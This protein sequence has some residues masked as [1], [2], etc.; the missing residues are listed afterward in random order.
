MLE[1]APMVGG[2][3][4]RQDHRDYDAALKKIRETE[5]KPESV[6]TGDIA[7]FCLAGVLAVALYLAP[8]KTPLWVCLGLTCMAALATHPVLN[9]PWIKKT[10]TREQRIGRRALGLCGM[11][12]L[13]GLYGWFVWPK[14][15]Y[16][17]DLTD[18]QAEHFIGILKGQ[19]GKR[20]ELRVGCSG[21]SE[22]VC[23]VA[24]KYIEMFQRGG[25]KVQGP[26]VQR[27]S[28]PKPM[29]GVVVMIRGVGTPNYDNPDLGIWTLESQSRRTIREAFLSLGI[30]VEEQGDV[31]M[32][33]E[34][35]GIYFGPS[36]S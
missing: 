32:P 8:E 24:R 14:V 20:Y 15:P 31:S 9:V 10:T 13:V 18:A 4:S 17:H 12:V 29:S 22:D 26:A 1:A 28:L 33:E 7:L 11:I 21:S 27:M 19:E 30:K 34:V 3:L 16:Y 23:V 35:L 2:I 5:R 6:S 25:W 36:P